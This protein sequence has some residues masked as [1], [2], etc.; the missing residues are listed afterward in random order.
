MG[1]RHALHT[2][3]LGLGS[4]L[5][6][7]DTLLRAGIEALGERV[8]VERISSVYDTAPMLVTDQPRF[9]NVV[10]RGRTALDPLALLRFAKGIEASLGRVPG[11]RYG[12]RP[13]DI[14][15]LLY[16][17]QVV[18]MAELSVP[19]PDIAARAFVLAPLAEIAPRLHIPGLDGNVLELLGR[20]AYADV[21]RDGHL[22][23]HRH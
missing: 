6:D 12:P 3:Y 22:F 13:L 15:I 16:D 21:R 10:C 1:Q 8:T 14:D 2:V 23:R 18:R 17:Q 4:N 7:R 20:L 11:R 19:H 9:H 5:G